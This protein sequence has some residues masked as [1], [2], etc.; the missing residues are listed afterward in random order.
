MTLPQVFVSPPQEEQ[1]MKRLHL[2]ALAAAAA[3]LAALLP[4]AGAHA[5]LGLSQSYLVVLKDS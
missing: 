4:A 2:F 3:A 5:G 1:A